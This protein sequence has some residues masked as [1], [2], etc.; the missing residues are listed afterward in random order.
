MLYKPKY[1]CNCSE[2]IER[3][4]WT[5]LT[6]RRFCDVCAVENRRHDNLPRLTVAAGVLSLMFGFGTLLGGSS[7]SVTPVQTL[8]SS[9]EPEFKRERT[10]E[11]K[12][13]QPRLDNSLPVASAKATGNS[14]PDFAKTVSDKTIVD[15]VHYCGALT[16]KGT[17]CSRKVKTAGSRCYQH[18]GKP[19][20][21]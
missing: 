14:S 4:D 11:R 19:S 20:V 6:S 1:C 9:S 5:L 13:D 7:G 8:S 3:I 12:D 16:K 10:I 18:E 21:F 15:T 17:P 2:K